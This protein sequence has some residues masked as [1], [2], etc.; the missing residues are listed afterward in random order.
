MHNSFVFLGEKKSDAL[1]KVSGV[2]ENPKRRQKSIKEEL[3]KTNDIDFPRDPA[4][5]PEIVLTAI[6]H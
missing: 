6:R 1:M 5:R 2:L 4:T 3:L